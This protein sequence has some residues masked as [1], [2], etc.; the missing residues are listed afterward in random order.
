MRYVLMILVLAGLALGALV[1]PQEVRA[2]AVDTVMPGTDTGAQI[3]AAVR[4]FV[5]QMSRM[6][7][8]FAPD[9]SAV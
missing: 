3:H 1:C 5:E 9:D 7:P 4:E 8:E 6:A 2:L